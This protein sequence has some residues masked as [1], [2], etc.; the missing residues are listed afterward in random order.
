MQGE[1]SL[2]QWF[3]QTIEQNPVS[4]Q[5]NVVCHFHVVGKNIR[6]CRI[7]PYVIKILQNFS[8]TLVLFIVS[9]IFQDW[10]NRIRYK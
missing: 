2:K 4:K 9:S 5:S 6:S 3:L 1:V 7:V 8:L 10:R